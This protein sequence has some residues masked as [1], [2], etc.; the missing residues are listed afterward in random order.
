MPA[1]FYVVAK[2]AIAIFYFLAANV[3]VKIVYGRFEFER[4][5]HHIIIAKII[6]MAIGKF[7]EIKFGRFKIEQAHSFF[8]LLRRQAI[9]LQYLF[10]NGQ[11]RVFKILTLNTL[12]ERG[13]IA[14]THRYRTTHRSII[15][16][17]IHH[18]LRT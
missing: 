16:A 14:G 1:F 4:I 11:F 6:R 18:L 13:E 7:G 5:V 8:N 10:G 12:L 17:D 2:K 15:S 9:I 3:F